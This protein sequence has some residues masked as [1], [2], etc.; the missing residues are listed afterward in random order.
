MPPQLP[1]HD[2]I[3]AQPKRGPGR[4]RKQVKRSR[5]S[6]TG[7]CDMSP[8]EKEVKIRKRVRFEDGVEQVE[9]GD[10]VVE[11]KMEEGLKSK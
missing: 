4:P 2:E 6:G 11:P 8:A 9:A 7:N 10:K 5:S 3:E 1:V